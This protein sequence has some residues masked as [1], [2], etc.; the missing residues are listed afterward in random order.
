MAEP[1][2][3]PPQ[4]D[5]PEKKAKPNA[6][7][8]RSLPENFRRGGRHW[9]REAQTVPYSEFT[10]EQLASIRAEKLLD[11]QE[12]VLKSDSPEA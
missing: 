3:N 8:V 6:I 2:S 10:N 5:K 11:V 12:V 4:N 9:T 1:N 7:R